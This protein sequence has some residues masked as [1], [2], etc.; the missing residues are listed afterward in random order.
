MKKEDRDE[1]D[2]I[3]AEEEAVKKEN[4]LLSFLLP[5]VGAIA[6]ILG[7]V[8]FILTLNSGLIGVVIF[9]AILFV[10]GLLGILYGALLIVRIK[11]PD[12]LKKKKAVE[13]D[14]VLAD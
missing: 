14:T 2:R 6:F 11:K 4:K 3:K 9:Y 5:I 13:E 7:L 12:F 1:L 8:G 10:I